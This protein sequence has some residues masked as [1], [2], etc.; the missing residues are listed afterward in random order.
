MYEIIKVVWL[1]HIFQ[2]KKIS[3]QLIG[4]IQVPVSARTVWSVTPA[5]SVKEASMLWNM[6]CTLKGFCQISKLIKNSSFIGP[7]SHFLGLIN[8]DNTRQYMFLESEQE[9]FFSFHFVGKRKPYSSL[10]LSIYIYI[11]WVFNKSFT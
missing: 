5:N 6:Y 4:C 11:Y 1:G 8:Q 3:G 9:D 10:N 7:I 2:K